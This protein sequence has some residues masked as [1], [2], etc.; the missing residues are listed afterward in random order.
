MAKSRVGG[1]YTHKR[2]MSTFER[3]TPEYKLWRLAVYKRD[4][5]QC[6][7]CGKKVCKGRKIQA[8]HILK[9][10]EYPTLRYDVNN[11]IT[12]CWECHKILYG[13]ENSYVSMCKM[14]IGN[15]ETFVKV[16]RMLRE[17]MENDNG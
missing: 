7:K 11:G 3:N 5:F 4:G 13:N 9:W 10:S 12:L 6:K 17:E 1:N 15:K 2:Y 16:Q 14:L 8:H